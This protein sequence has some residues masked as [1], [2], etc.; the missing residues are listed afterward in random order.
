MD[1]CQIWEP[2]GWA[3]PF[4][5][6]SKRKQTAVMLESTNSLKLENI[7][8]EHIQNIHHSYKIC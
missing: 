8:I 1:F 2:L 3:N 7:I 4:C 6:L 5:R